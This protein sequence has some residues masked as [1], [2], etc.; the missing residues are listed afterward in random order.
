MWLMWGFSIM[1]GGQARMTRLYSQLGDRW[2]GE[3][4]A[5]TSPMSQDKRVF[6]AVACWRYRL[7]EPAKIG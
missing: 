1:N 7:A 2:T 3:T 6:N 4:S 5:A